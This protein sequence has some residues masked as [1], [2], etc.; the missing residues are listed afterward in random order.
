MKTTNVLIALSLLAAGVC[1]N[2]QE[3]LPKQIKVGKERVKA[4][5]EI[6]LPQIDRYNLLKCDFHIHTIFSARYRLADPAGA[7]SLGR[8]PGCNRPS[9][10]ISKDNRHARPSKRVIITTLS[11]SPKRKRHAERLFLS[12]GVKSP[13]RCPP[14]PFECSV[15]KRCECPR[16]EG[17]YES[18]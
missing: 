18:N 8:R 6:R 12:K 3:A 11:T 10:T 13:V 15:R 1:V 16:P 17:L 7:G 14:G 2:A 4:R 5:K 9:P